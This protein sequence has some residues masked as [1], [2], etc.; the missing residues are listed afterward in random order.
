MSDVGYQTYK[1]RH[2]RF[3]IIFPSSVF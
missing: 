2:S 3:F 1:N